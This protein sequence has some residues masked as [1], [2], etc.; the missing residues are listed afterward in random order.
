MTEL[1]DV[2]AF[3]DWNAGFSSLPLQLRLASRSLRCLSVDVWHLQTH[4]AA[5]YL[6][7]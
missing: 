6:G 3:L 5:V 1:Y 7:C 2:Y 4:I